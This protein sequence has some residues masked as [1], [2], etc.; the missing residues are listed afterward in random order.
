MRFNESCYIWFDGQHELIRVM[1]NFLMIAAFLRGLFLSFDLQVRLPFI[2]ELLPIDSVI[3]NLDGLVI[4]SSS[5][6][7]T[8]F[9]YNMSFVI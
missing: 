8:F 6:I 5:F 2:Q 3:G 4:V 9:C 1:P 7:S